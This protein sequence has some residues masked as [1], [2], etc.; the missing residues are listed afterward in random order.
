M[1][2]KAVTEK[3][4]R[5][6]RQAGLDVSPQ[7]S[8][9]AKKPKQNAPKVNA[10]LQSPAAEMEDV[11]L[12][13]SEEVEQD[14]EP[15]EEEEE[16]KDDETEPPEEEEDKDDDT[17]PPEEEE[18]ED[19]DDE[20]EPPEEEDKDDETE[21]PINRV[22]TP[23]ETQTQQSDNQVKKTRG[24][25]KMRKVAK[26]IED[27]GR[28]NLTEE[29]QKDVVFKQMG[30]LW[31]ASKSRLSFMVRATKNKAQLQKMKPNNIQSAT[32]WNNW[33]KG[34]CTSAFQEQSDKYRELRKGQIPHTTSRK[35]MIR[36]ADD[37]KKNT[38]DPKQVTRTKV[39]VAGH[40]HSDRRPVH[41]EFADTIEKIKRIDSEMDSSSADNIGEDAVSQVLGK[42]KP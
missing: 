24:P 6:K 16:D 30:C 10:E 34:R 1:T 35:G 9:T 8:L 5:S 13:G 14:A 31:R 32:S 3:A 23:S 21:P 19:K 36:L 22:S 2:S 15:E 42:D 17:E 40:T 38:S 4:R 39:W 27:K 29:W 25:T 12:T 18:E 33:V 26:H 20:T 28:F 41:E 37:V 7:L 11:E